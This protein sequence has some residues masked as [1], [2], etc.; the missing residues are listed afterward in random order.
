[1]QTLKWLDPDDEWLGL[2]AEEITDTHVQEKRRLPRRAESR[3]EG[4]MGGV[5]ENV[6]EAFCLV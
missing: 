2:G 3:R 6:W 1:M 4:L 5:R